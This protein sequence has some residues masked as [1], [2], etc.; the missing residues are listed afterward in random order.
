MFLVWLQ[1]LSSDHMAEV[2]SLSTKKVAFC[3]FELE[4]CLL[5]AF[6]DKLQMVQVLFQCP[7]V[8]DD[9]VDETSTAR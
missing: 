1:S 8:D 9:N 2:F 5:E 3:G 6:Y 7:R 4:P